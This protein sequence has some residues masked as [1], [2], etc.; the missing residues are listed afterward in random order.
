MIMSSITKYKTVDGLIKF[1]LPCSPER[2]GDMT[3]P[4]NIMKG[5]RIFTSIKSVVCKQYKVEYGK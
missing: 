4:T 1:N 3:P 5:V 2:P